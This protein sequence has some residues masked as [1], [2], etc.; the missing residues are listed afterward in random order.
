MGGHRIY[1]SELALM[2]A[3]LG[4]PAYTVALGAQ[5]I[6]LWRRGFGQAGRR[7]RLFAILV[8]SAVCS[9]LLTFLVWIAVPPVLM[10]WPGS[11]GHSPFMF[12]GV[13]FIPA[14]LGA[15]VACSAIGWYAMRT[16]G[17]ER[18][19]CRGRGHTP[20]R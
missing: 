7:R 3:V 16:R 17:S 20:V 1:L 18:L 11:M 12:L 9:Y 15:G 8:A 2:G 19:S 14:L 4:A 5:T 13:F 6:V 10:D